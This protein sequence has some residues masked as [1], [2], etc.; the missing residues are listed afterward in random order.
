MAKLGSGLITVRISDHLPVFAFVGGDK[1]EEG[2]LG[3]GGKRRLVNEGR[4]VRFAEELE[5]WSFDEEG[6]LGAEENVCEV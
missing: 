4:I 2:S 6:A 5:G 1:E 3:G